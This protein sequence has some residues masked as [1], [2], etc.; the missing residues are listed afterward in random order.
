MF[1]WLRQRRR[2][3]LREQ[4]FPSTW[5]EF[6]RRNVQQ[7]QWLDETE[8]QYLREW[9]AVFIAE[10][11]FEG[12]GGLEVT[13]E[14]RVT[15]AAQAGLIV[16]GFH[17]EYFESLRSIIVYP[18]DYVASRAIPLRGGGELAWQEVRLGETWS[19]GSVVLAWSRVLEGGRQQHGRRNVVLHEFAHLV[20]LFDGVIDGVPLL[21]GDRKR[22]EMAFSRCRNTFENSLENNEPTILDAYAAEG[23]SEFFAVATECFFQDPHRLASH[24]D[25]LYE[26]LRLA[27]RQDPKSRSPILHDG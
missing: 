8:R 25:E 1:A 27:W 14:I 24:D 16:L 13:D 3:A 7:V 4:P 17:N 20:D 11:Y 15:I 9:I 26:L 5:D 6:I 10:K 19:G 18:S 12:C 23:A 2:R 22:W 21:E